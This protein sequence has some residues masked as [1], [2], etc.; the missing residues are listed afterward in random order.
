MVGKE[1]LEEKSSISK[2][3]VEALDSLGLKSILDGDGD[4]AFKSLIGEGKVLIAVIDVE[5]KEFF[6]VNYPR[7][8]KPENLADEAKVL[9]ACNYANRETKLA[10]LYLSAD[11]SYVWAAY[12]VQLRKVDIDHL[13][14]ALRYSMAVIEAAVEQFSEALHDKKM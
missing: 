1:N 9:R 14:D 8:Y 10:K 13:K 3:Y 12:E 11:G 5:H 6:R 2:L 4:V 7:V